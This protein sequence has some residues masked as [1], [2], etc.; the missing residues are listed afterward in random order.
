MNLHCVSAY[1]YLERRFHPGLRRFGSLL[2]MA[3]AIG[4]MGTMLYAVGL[5]L[6]TLLSLSDTGAVLAVIGVG[7]FVT[8]YTTLVDIKAVIWT[9]VVQSAVIVGSIS[10]ITLQYTATSTAVWPRSSHWDR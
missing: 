9:D 4:R 6:K 5:I 1:R 3:Y 2:F 10:L 8:V 7:L